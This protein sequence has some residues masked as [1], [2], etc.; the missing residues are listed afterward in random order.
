MPDPRALGLN[1]A[2]PDQVLSDGL[3]AEGM[4]PRYTRPQ[5]LSTPD[6]PLYPVVGA[7][8]LIARWPVIPP[9]RHNGAPETPM[10]PGDTALGLDWQA[11]SNLGLGPARR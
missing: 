1:S 8:N 7:Q 3:A 5:N 10:L 9:H 2:L 11:L 4:K 6:S